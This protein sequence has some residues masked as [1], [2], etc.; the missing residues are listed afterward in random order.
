MVEDA[1]SLTNVK[2]G[3]KY[4]QFFLFYSGHGC[5]SDFRTAGVDVLGETI[6]LEDDYVDDIACRPNTSL[7]A[8]FDCC[9]NKINF[10][11]TKKIQKAR[12]A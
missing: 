11:K 8:F 3:S 4:G 12:F 1:L 2:D 9:R 10:T 7:V 5:I 6:E